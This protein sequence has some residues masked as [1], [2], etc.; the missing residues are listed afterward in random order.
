MYLWTL[1]RF[2][3]NQHYL[4]QM[5]TRHFQLGRKRHKGRPVLDD[6]LLKKRRFIDKEV[7]AS[8]VSRA[9]ALDR[10]TANI[11]VQIYVNKIR[12]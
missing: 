6:I 11:N 7:K 9:V 8:M 3:V 1:N 5:N 12:Q 10:F 4:S 2:D